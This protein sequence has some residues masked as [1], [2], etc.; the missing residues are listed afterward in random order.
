MTNFVYRGEPGGW[1]VLEGGAT[2]VMLTYGFTLGRYFGC[3]ARFVCISTR[4]VCI[5]TNL[6]YIM[7]RFVY[8]YAL[9]P[10][11][12]AYDKLCLHHDKVC[13]NKQTLS[14]I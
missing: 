9:M 10:N 7:T 4:F 8:T 13:Y 12:P 3:M 11:L 6:V 5:V 14:C 1:G 2:A